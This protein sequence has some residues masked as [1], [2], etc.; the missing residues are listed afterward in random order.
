MA[1]SKPANA[2]KRRAPALP[3]EMVGIPGRL[4]QAM[5]EYAARR[6]VKKISQHELAEL[7]EVAQPAINKVL[8]SK[9]A[10]ATAVLLVR[11][12]HALEIM[13]GWLLTGEGPKR[14]LTV[15]TSPTSRGGVTVIDQ[16]FFPN[17]SSSH[18]PDENEAGR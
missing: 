9:S 8:K 17:R 4:A 6:G 10:G 7:A 11:L 18:P 5:A 2:L 1:E 3:E 14:R 16:K 15:P 12:A 13:P